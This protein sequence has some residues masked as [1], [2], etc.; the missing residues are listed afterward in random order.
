MGC[1]KGNSVIGGSYQEEETLTVYKV[2]KSF[3]GCHKLDLFIKQCQTQLRE[4]TG[5]KID[6]I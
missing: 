3:S 6:L 2:I 5:T 1:F 4:I